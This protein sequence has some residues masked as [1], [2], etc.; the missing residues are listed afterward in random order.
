VIGPLSVA[1]EGISRGFARFERAA[2]GLASADAVSN[3]PGAAV[4]L[5]SAKTEIRANT[6]VLRASD[7]LLGTLLDVLA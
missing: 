6:A 3:L 4:D 2:A 7:R 1:S 5:V